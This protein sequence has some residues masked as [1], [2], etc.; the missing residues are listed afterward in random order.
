[1]QYTVCHELGHAWGLPHTDEIFGN[2]GECFGSSNVCLAEQ[3]LVEE[4][5]PGSTFLAWPY[6]TWEIAWITLVS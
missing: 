1:M 6:Q 3:C 2:K 4:G 5:S